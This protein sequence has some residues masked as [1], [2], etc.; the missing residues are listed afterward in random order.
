MLDYFVSGYVHRVEA[1]FRKTDTR[2]SV[3]ERLFDTV[4][5]DFNNNRSRYRL[6]LLRGAIAQLA[7][8]NED[9]AAFI[10]AKLAPLVESVRLDKA[11]ADTLWD[12]LLAFL[13]G[14]CV[15]LALVDESSVAKLSK[16]IE[17]F[18]CHIVAD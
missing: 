1:E 15:R 5:A 6:P 18:L 12:V 17:T 7:R 14:I 16:S 3:V 2:D 9:A 11:T 4:L 10:R 13:D 8:W